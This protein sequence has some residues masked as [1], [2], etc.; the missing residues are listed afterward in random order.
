[1]KT[2]VLSAILIVVCVL[3]CT[4]CISGKY[5]NTSDSS[6][7]IELYIGCS[8]SSGSGYARNVYTPDL[9]LTGTLNY[10]NDT[11]TVTVGRINYIYSRSQISVNKS[12]KSITFKGYT[13]KK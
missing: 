10:S 12:A 13:Y 6:S 5:T 8:E 4:G 3:S 1:M 9:L 7:Y 11:A 2:K